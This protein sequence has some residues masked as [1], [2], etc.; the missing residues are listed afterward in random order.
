[1]ANLQFKKLVIVSDLSI[2]CEKRNKEIANEEM[3]SSVIST[4]FLNFY[5]LRRNTSK[6]LTKKHTLLSCKANLED[7]EIFPINVGN[8]EAVEPRLQE[9]YNPSQ[10]PWDFYDRILEEENY[11][12][13]LEFVTTFAKSK[14]LAMVNESGDLLLSSQSEAIRKEEDFNLLT[15]AFTSLP[16]QVNAETQDISRVSLSVFEAKQVMR[17]LD[18]G[19]TVTDMGLITRTYTSLSAYGLIPNFGSNSPD[20][21]DWLHLILALQ[22]VF[23]KKN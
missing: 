20:G 14:Y 18:I 8:A 4:I 17:I 2:Y 22:Y 13:A 10:A 9:I 19:L 15:E 5:D 1:M 12:A 6:V 16:S 21:E 11:E 3:K 7:R 23:C